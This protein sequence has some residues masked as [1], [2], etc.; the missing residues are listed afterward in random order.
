M[1]SSSNARVTA[2][3]ERRSINDN[4]TISKPRVMSGLSGSKTERSDGRTPQSPQPPGGGPTHKRMPSGSQRISRNVEER[5]TEKVQV[6]TRETLT[7]RIRSP[8]QRPSTSVV[9]AERPRPVESTRTNSKDITSK[10]TRTEL[11]QGMAPIHPLPRMSSAN[12]LTLSS[13]TMESRSKPYTTYNRT[14]GLPDI[15]TT[16]CSASPTVPTA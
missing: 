12:F 6:I 3:T 16:A 10:P 13:S 8:D 7:S 11:P 14:T 9:A 2:Q 1:S 15:Y 5:R 4:S